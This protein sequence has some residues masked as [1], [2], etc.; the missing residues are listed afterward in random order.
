MGSLPIEVLGSAM[1][2]AKH[3]GPDVVHRV[4]GAAVLGEKRAGQAG[5][6]IGGKTMAP[7]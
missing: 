6:E 2:Q 3:V 1:R 5:L 4:Q 7:G